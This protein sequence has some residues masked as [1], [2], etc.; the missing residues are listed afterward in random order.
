MVTSHLLSERLKNYLCSQH[1]CGAQITVNQSKHLLVSGQA[2]P[3]QARINLPNIFPTPNDG[4]GVLG[5]VAARNLC[6]FV[7]LFLSTWIPNSLTW[8]GLTLS[9]SIFS[10]WFYLETG[11]EIFFLCEDKSDND[12]HCL[13][14]FIDSLSRYSGQNIIRLLKA[15]FLYIWK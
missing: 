12:L 5:R 14:K 7:V 13:M 9:F 8:P 4:W 1:Y 15:S 10:L 11:F 6:I 3:G 2:R